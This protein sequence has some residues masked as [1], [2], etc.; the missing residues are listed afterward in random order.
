MAINTLITFY[1]TYL[2]IT[3]QRLHRLR[4]NSL[5]KDKEAYFSHRHTLGLSQQV[6]TSNQIINTAKNRLKF[7][8]FHLLSINLSM[9]IHFM[10]LFVYVTR[11]AN[12]KGLTS[13]I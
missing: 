2:N 11:V 13:S 3:K 12:E 7:N 8:F 6:I 9:Y 4:F 5:R 10:Y 1:T